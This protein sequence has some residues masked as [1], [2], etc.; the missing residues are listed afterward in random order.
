[1]I[2]SSFSSSKQASN[3]LGEFLELYKNTRHTLADLL[4]VK[5]H[6]QVDVF[7]KGLHTCLDMMPA[8]QRQHQTE[9]ELA[10]M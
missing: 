5:N 8:K 7:C 9:D 4:G 1:M 2:T 6:F 3:A 10:P